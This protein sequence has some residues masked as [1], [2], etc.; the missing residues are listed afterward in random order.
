[1]AVKATTDVAKGVRTST[2]AAAKTTPTAS[3]P[4]SWSNPNSQFYQASST[5]ATPAAKTT[6]AGPTNP[7]KVIGPSAGKSAPAGQSTDTGTGTPSSS[8]AA[9]AGATAA[10]NA[11]LKSAGASDRILAQ[12][13]SAAEAG[14][15]AADSAARGASDYQSEQDALLAAAGKGKYSAPAAVDDPLMYSGF[16]DSPTAEANMYGPDAAYGNHDRSGLRNPGGPGSKG[17]GLPNAAADGAAAGVAAGVT[18]AGEGDDSGSDKGKGNGGKGKGKGGGGGW[19]GGGGSG[20][21]TT[22]A[23]YPT[24]EELLAQALGQAGVGVGG[25]AGVGGGT[26]VSGTLGGSTAPYE[27]PEMPGAN[28]ERLEHVDT[29]ELR[30]MLQQILDAQKE[31]TQNTVDYNVQRETE[32]LNRAMEDA[33]PQ[34]QTQ[35]DQVAADEMNALDNQALYAEARGDRGGIGEAQYASIQ[36]A[37]NQNRRA[38][39]DAQVKLST[40]TARQISDLRAQGEFEK[41]DQL[42]SLTQSYLSQLMNLEQWALQENMSVDQFNSQLQQWVDEYNMNVQK[43]LTDLDLSQAN[44]TGVFAN[45]NATRATQNQ[46]IETLANAGTALLNAGV[47]PSQQQLNA[48]GMTPTQAKAYIAKLAQMKK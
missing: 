12:L 42:L 47:L 18:T 44:L 34:F 37:A 25:G 11:G 13:R 9:V 48:M 19:Y 36:A 28:P 38:V 3:F 2:P 22:P 41:A 6:P 23:N 14:R 26:N 5:P 4:S 39:N 32:A 29:T 40:D 33:A 21:S 30:N 24:D 35:R 10:A 43:Y 46:L 31:Q 16:A 1:M 15:A 45:G 7:Q 20:G 27:L 17:L 8:A